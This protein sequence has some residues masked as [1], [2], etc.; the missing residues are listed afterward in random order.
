MTKLIYAD[1]TYTLRGTFFK[2][3]RNLKGKGSHSGD[4]IYCQIIRLHRKHSH[5]LIFY[6]QRGVDRARGLQ[7]LNKPSN[8]TFNMPGKH[9]IN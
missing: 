1:L 8:H 9:L 2:V 7:Q 5:D 6:D 4:L 3:Y